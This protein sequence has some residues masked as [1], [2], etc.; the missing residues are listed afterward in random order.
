MSN[1]NR[2]GSRSASPAKQDDES[3]DVWVC[4]ICKKTFSDPK[5]HI[6]DSVSEIFLVYVGHWPSRNRF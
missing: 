2:A 5:A 4:Q 1:R 6:M 3:D